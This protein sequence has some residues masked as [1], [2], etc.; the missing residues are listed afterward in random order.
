MPFDDIFQAY[1]TLYRLEAETPA[2][3]DDEYTIALELSK[4]AIN[5]WENY[6]N[7]YWKELFGTL[8]TATDGTNTITSGTTDYSA[9][10]DMKEAGGFVKI[11]N[12]DGNTITTYPIIEPQ[13]AQFKGDSTVYSYFTG[14]PSDGFTLHLNPAPTSST[15]GMDIDYVYYKVA[16]ELA[17]GSDT[18]ECP[19]S[20]FIVHRMLYN[21]FRGSRN[22]YLN[23]ALRDGED[24]LKTMKMANDSG[25]WANPWNVADNS[26]T[27]WGS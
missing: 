2:S 27:S 1:Y 18:T 15:D 8:Q 14:N 22:P 20:Y 4:E 23:T 6:E 26:G 13:E 7:T 17:T 5:R 19:N 16:T 11:K 10:T 24:T 3:T 12:S 21:R 9:P 25:T